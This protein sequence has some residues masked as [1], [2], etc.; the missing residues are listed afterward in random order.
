MNKPKFKVGDKVRILPEIDS[1]RCVREVIKVNDDCTYEL[2]RS[3]GFWREEKLE[4]VEPYDRQK[5]FLTRLGALLEEF[6]A[7]IY[8]EEGWRLYIDLGIHSPTEYARIRYDLQDMDGEL[9]AKDVFI[10]S[11]IFKR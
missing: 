7:R 5:D 10:N 9:R 2:S 8:D 3:M 11:K 4:L 1:S 6:D